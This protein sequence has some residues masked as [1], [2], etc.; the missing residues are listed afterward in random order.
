MLAKVDP[1]SPVPEENA[2]EVETEPEP[3]VEK[4]AKAKGKKG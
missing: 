3:K 1:S 2:A 4:V